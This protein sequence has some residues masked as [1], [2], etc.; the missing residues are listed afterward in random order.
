MP[1]PRRAKAR[2]LN[3]KQVS[4]RPFRVRDYPFFFMHWIITKNNQNIGDALRELNLTPAIWRI[5]ALL[6]ERDGISVTELSESSLIDRTLLS[7]LLSDLEQR[8]FVRKRTDPKDKRYIGIY[9]APAGAKAF[10]EI[11]PIA[12]RQIERA[13]EGLNASE[14]AQLKKTLTIIIRNLSRSPYA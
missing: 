11:M 7:R 6:Q 1:V 13:L 5:L 3:R 12:R 9:L 14:L 2:T 10:A 8:G 4:D